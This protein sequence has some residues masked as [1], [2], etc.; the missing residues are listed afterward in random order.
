MLVLI[1]LD[2]AHE[3]R[4]RM[5]A[6]LA[7]RGLAFERL[8]HDFRGLDRREIRRWYAERLPTVR[9]P[10]YTLSGAELGCWASHL[11]AWARIHASG[12]PVGTVLEDDVLLA[13]DFARSAGILEHDLGGFDLVYLGTSSRNLSHRRAVTVGGLRVHAPVGLVVNTWGYVVSAAWIGRLLAQPS[14]AIDQPVDHYLGGRGGAI[15]PR[16]GVLQPACVHEDPA[17]APASQIQPHTW[18][19]DRLR[20]A[21]SARRRFLQSRAG[22][23]FYR[24][25]RWL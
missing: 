24:L 16:I 17:T 18:R 1:N 7:A 19:P 3:R 10:A 22:D 12:A 21:E 5:Q 14:F 9:P 15:R 4:A 13:A 23:W 8:G 25:Y 20:V 6:Q 11:S 2:G